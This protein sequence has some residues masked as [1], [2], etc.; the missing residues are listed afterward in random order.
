MVSI[1][2]KMIVLHGEHE[3]LLKIEFDFYISPLCQT[4]PAGPIFTIFGM[5]CHIADVITR[6]KY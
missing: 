5:W 4:S 2:S 3:I 6:V 1:L